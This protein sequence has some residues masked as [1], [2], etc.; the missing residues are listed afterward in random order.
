MDK[1]VTFPYPHLLRYLPMQAYSQVLGP[2]T[3]WA[4]PWPFDLFYCNWCFQLR[5]RSC[6]AAI[7]PILHLEV[8]NVDQKQVRSVSNL[9][10][11]RLVG[12]LLWVLKTWLGENP[13]E[14][15]LTSSICRALV[16]D[17]LRIYYNVIDAISQDGTFNLTRLGLSGCV[18]YTPNHSLEKDWLT[19]S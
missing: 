17:I 16:S 10:R 7:P 5:V 18:I 4:L 12:T 8:T 19:F 15:R 3:S 2:W 13:T 9:L 1:Y 14:L 6:D 11:W